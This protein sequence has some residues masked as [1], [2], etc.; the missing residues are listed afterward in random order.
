[1]TTKSYKWGIIGLGKIA[2]KFAEDLQRVEGAELYA[3]ASRSSEKAEEFAEKFEAAKSYNSY[4][5]LAQDP[6]VDII[7]IATPHVFHHANTIMCIQNKKAVLCEKP[8]G[9]NE[10][11]VQEMIA[12]AR[13][14]N[15]FLMEA[16]WTHFL[17]HF[18]YILDLV[19]TKK[20][21]KLK[22][23][24]AD[25]GFEAPF[26]SEKRIFNKE[27]GGGS[28]LDVG[29]YPVFA[30]MTLLGEPDAI[31]ATGTIG[32]TGVDEDCTINFSYK[33]AK[34]ELSSAINKTT[35]TEAKLIFEDAEVLIRSRFHEP[36]SLF[37][38]SNG[39]EETRGF[40]VESIGYN[41][42]AAHIQKMLSENRVEST[43]MTHKKSLLLISLL[44]KI[45]K[46]IALE[47]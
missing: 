31:S 1:M 45:R 33:N 8:M 4:E 38:K 22:E 42:E 36:T 37:I 6:D 41:F 21:G 5:A 2:H 29:I 9:I 35:N 11:Q 17:P 7:Y 26:N 16:L 44:D 30:A 28:L 20:F 15:V 47:Y 10:H 25:F 39:K 3:V 27:L 34:A 43:V 14:E 46:Q 32:K 40:D 19:E 23:L 18:E 13:T 24:T 12:A